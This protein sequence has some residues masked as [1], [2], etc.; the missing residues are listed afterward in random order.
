MSTTATRLG[1]LRG[2]MAERGYD[3]FLVPRTDE[4]LGEYI[5]AHNERLRWLTGFTGSAGVAVVLA[6]AAAIFVDGRYTVQVRQQVDAGQF[7]VRHLVDE[8]HIR[9]LA[10]QLP[11]GATVACDPRL[12]SLQWYRASAALLEA[13]GMRLVEDA[14]NL[15]DRA[16]EDRPSPEIGTALLLAEQYSG[17]SSAG[18]R[19]RIA[20][21]VSAAGA[22]AALVFA[23]DAVSWLLNVRGTDVPN[24]PVLQGFALLWA[25]GDMTLYADARRLPE[26]FAAH[27]GE[28]VRVVGEE[29]FIAHAADLAGC[30]VLADP[31][32]ANAWTQLALQ[33]AGAEL[34]A[35]SDPVLIPKAC[36]NAREVA[37]ARRAHLRDAVAM[38]R[39]LAWLDAEVEAG[40][41]HD[42]AELAD[43]LY[44]YR[45]A[46]EHFHGSS[47]DTISAAAGNAAMCHYNHENAA[48]PGRLVMNTVYLVDSGAQYI[49]GTTDITRTVAIGDPGPEVRRL[50]T[51]V[52][53][54]HIALDRA[55]FPRGTT[56][57]HLDAIARQFLW[58]AGFDYDH[59]TGHGVG[60]FLSVH[61][62]PQRISKSWSD[63]ALRPGMILSNE[64]GYYRD[65]AFGIRCENLV[66]VQEVEDGLETPMLCFD[67]LTLAPFDRRLLW[68]ELLDARER[69]WLDSYHQRVMDTVGPLLDEPERR[70]LARVTRPI[71]D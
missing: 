38:A 37:G 67:A 23:P 31:A 25:G 66:V 10:G 59:G 27:V 12:H 21:D 56:G 33:A 11:D 52:L 71:G 16:W 57:T 13:A 44:A 35:G 45:A 6:D 50:F 47:F 9:W 30:K 36:K 14:D 18:K 1:A 19:A 17:E 41:L 4:S 68:P 29:S 3:A 22:R 61:E 60:A 39:F 43:Q 8:P 46:G 51:L 34:V 49:D 53:K 54:G 24:L 63:T 42:E 69:E 15:V 28:G 26:G 32:Q 7:E 20:A 40:R 70:W 55:R 64:P 58:R 65:G 2:L 5:P 62:G 48:Q